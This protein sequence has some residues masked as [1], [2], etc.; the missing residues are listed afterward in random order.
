MDSELTLWEQNN[1]LNLLELLKQSGQAARLRP[2]LP[3]QSLPSAV[4]STVITKN[5]TSGIPRPTTLSAAHFLE[6]V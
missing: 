2:R 1:L 3:A 5:F 4:D 6:I